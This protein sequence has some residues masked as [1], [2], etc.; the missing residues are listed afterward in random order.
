LAEAHAD[1]VDDVD[2]HP[3]VLGE[4]DLLVALPA[5]VFEAPLDVLDGDVVGVGAGA[6]QEFDDDW[7]AGSCE[8]LRDG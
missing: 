1:D 2:A 5:G 7:R 4:V 6:A 3:G 8:I